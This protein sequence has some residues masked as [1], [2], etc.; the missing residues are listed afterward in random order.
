[1]RKITLLI[2]ILLASVSLST[3]AETDRGVARSA[4]TTA[5]VDREPVSDLSSFSVEDGKVYFFTEL[6]NLSGKKIFHQW[7]HNY[8]VYAVVNFEVGGPRW[9][10][11]SSKNMLPEWEG[12]WKVNV[13]VEPYELV[14]SYT[15]NYG[16]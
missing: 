4:F 1:M 9:R 3:L 14:G 11:Y 16:E 5:V 8:K 13:F 7:I 10:V 2:S 12:E 6:V 15:F